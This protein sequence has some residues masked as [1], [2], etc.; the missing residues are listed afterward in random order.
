MANSSGTKARRAWR[1]KLPPEE[2]R[3]L[4]PEMPGSRGGDGPEDHGYEEQPEGAPKARPRDDLAKRL[5]PHGGHLHALRAA[6]L[7]LI[8]WSAL[9]SDTLEVGSWFPAAVGAYVGLVAVAEKA[10]RTW[11][12]LHGV[13]TLLM[14]IADGVFL[15]LILDASGGILSPLRFLVYI[16]LIAATLVYT[17]RVGI[18]VTIMHSVML[19]AV[20]R[21]QSSGLVDFQAALPSAG[22]IGEGGMSL[23][24]SWVF[25]AFILWVIALATAPFSSV[26]ERE[27]RRRKDDLSAVA[28]LAADF[29][30]LHDPEEIASVMVE[31]VCDSFG[32]RRAVVLAVRDERL[33]VVARK[34]DVQEAAPSD[35]VDRVIDRAWDAHEALLVARLNDVS[36]PLLSGLLPEARN[37]LVAPMYADGQPVGVVVA[38]SGRP[39]EVVIQRRVISLVMQFASHGALAM[40]NAWLLQ[41][42]RVMADTDGLTGVANRRSFEKAIERDVSRSI[43][44][45]E[46]LTLV[47]LDL[48]HFK[49]LNDLFGH[50][51]GDDVLR[52]VGAVLRSA[53]RESDVP[54][55]YGGEEFAVLLPGCSK[56]EAFAAAERLR[57]LVAGVQAPVPVTCSA[58]VATYPLNATT[59]T[60]LVAAADEALYHSKRMGRDLT[61]LSPR[62]RLAPVTAGEAL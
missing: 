25:N 5:S 36:D 45:G 14:L 39:D 18:P 52:Q 9:F 11:S 20:Y 54:A 57:A 10:G 55:R 13:A 1:S 22:D 21:A 37:L 17:H 28:N 27:L 41:Q 15:G 19:Y 59:S 60:Q 56:G 2:A 4:A 12:R 6:F 61:A 26:N 31:R 40:R 16:H 38:E 46:P 42:V 49:Q 50:Q 47:M 58:G 44:S 24:Q 33:V 3:V 8:G 53:S 7:V 51:A 29:E 62:R 23:Q 48:D 30:S 35:R 34:G 32:F 43:R